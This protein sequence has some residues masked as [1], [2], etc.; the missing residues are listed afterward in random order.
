MRFHRN[1]N[2]SQKSL[3]PDGYFALSFYRK[4]MSLRFLLTALF[5]SSPL[6]S[7]D[8]PRLQF[9][10]DLGPGR[11]QVAQ[12]QNASWKKA[13]S[14]TRNEITLIRKA[15]ESALL[16]SRLA[17]AVAQKS[18]KPE[19]QQ[20]TARI[21]QTEGRARQWM[22][23]LAAAKGVSLPAQLSATSS[24]NLKSLLSNQPVDHQFIDFIVENRTEN[25]AVLKAAL[26]QT[27]DSDFKSLLE[28]LI[29]SYRMDLKLARNLQVR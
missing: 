1:P 22:Q 26:A 5:I 4:N 14:L 29:P 17:Q 16:T 27:S 8:L 18:S 24:S 3:L 9:D 12:F 6:Y 2:H 11:L 25:V 21:S 15:A 13:S 19:I 10:D 20:L 7:A 23:D 28:T